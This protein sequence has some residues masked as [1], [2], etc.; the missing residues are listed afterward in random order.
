MPR[1]SPL[2]DPVT[3]LLAWA[4]LRRLMG[5]AMLL[6]VT[7]VAGAMV[8]VWRHGAAARA[9]RW[10]AVALGLGLAMLVLSGLAGL[11]ALSRARRGGRDQAG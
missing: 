10:I 3:A 1:H 4:R 11:R 7:L 2:D 5:C 8:M 9:D 6:T